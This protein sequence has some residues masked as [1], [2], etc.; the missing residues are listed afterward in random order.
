VH[1]LRTDSLDYVNDPGSRAA[2]QGMVEG[3]LGGSPVPGAPPRYG[4]TAQPSLFGD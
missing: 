1:V 3:W 2:I 4:A